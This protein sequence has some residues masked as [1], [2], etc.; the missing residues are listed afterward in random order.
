[1]SN[2]I[3]D[4]VW[5]GMVWYGMIWYDMVCYGRNLNVSRYKRSN[6]VLFCARHAL[7]VLIVSLIPLVAATY[8]LN[9]G[10]S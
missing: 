9:A 2:V 5:Y 4:T 8:A 7:S 1:M 10:F 6:G 3:V